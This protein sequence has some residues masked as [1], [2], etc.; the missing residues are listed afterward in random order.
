MDGK[1][2]KKLS[3]NLFWAGVGGLSLILVGSAYYVYNLFV[4]DEEELQEDQLKQIEQIK[5]DMNS[6]NAGS[7]GTGA[8]TIERAMEIMVMM[9][10]LADDSFK[11]NNA[12]LDTR[13]RKAIDNEVEY[14]QLCM[15][16]FECKEKYYQ[17]ASQTVMSNFGSVSMEDIQKVLAGRNPMEIEKISHK[18]DKQS[19]EG[20][21]QPNKELTK[22]AFLNFGETMQK[23]MLGLQQMMRTLQANPSQ[24]QEQMYFIQMLM[25]KMKV[26]DR[27]FNKYG[28]TEPEIKYMIFEHNMWEDPEIKRTYQMMNGIEQMMMGG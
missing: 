22:E 14:R 13:R 20:K 3:E 6:E 11:K 7:S 27:L 26:D 10:R 23:E 21:S 19:F 5:K 9:N 25:I 4:S 16:S 1:N 24:E 12:D 15:E 17:Q 18:Y 2:N 28:Y 8:L